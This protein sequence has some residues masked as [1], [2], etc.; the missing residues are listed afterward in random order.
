MSEEFKE[1]TGLDLEAGVC[2]ECK[3]PLQ[4]DR[5]YCCVDCEEKILGEFLK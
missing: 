4:S 1:E 3:I 2:F 5:L